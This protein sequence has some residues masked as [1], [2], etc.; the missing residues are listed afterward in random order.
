MQLLWL[1]RL[2]KFVVVMCR[3]NAYGSEAGAHRMTCAFPPRY[4]FLCPGQQTQ[5]QLL[6]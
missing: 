2:G 1:E 3:A 6:G 4:S 5:R